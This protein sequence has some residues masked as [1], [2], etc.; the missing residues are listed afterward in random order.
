[1]AAGQIENRGI[2]YVANE[3]MLRSAIGEVV[4]TMESLKKAGLATEA[5]MLKGIV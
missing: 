1:M 2:T 5:K 3:E 4:K